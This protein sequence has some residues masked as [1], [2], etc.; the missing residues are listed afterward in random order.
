[1]KVTTTAAALDTEMIGDSNNEVVATKVATPA[2]A[3][4]TGILDDS[5]DKVDATKAPVGGVPAGTFLSGPD[6]SLVKVDDMA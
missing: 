3:L 1:M 6:C 2:G 4:D 5:N